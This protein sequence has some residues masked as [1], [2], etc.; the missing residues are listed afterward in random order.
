MVMRWFLHRTKIHSKLHSAVA[1]YCTFWMTISALMANEKW[2]SKKFLIVTECWYPIHFF[3]FI[4]ATMPTMVV[5][6]REC[7]SFRHGIFFFWFHVEHIK[8]SFSNCSGR[9]M[10]PSGGFRS[11]LIR[12][13]THSTLMKILFVFGEYDFLF[14]IN[15]HCLDALT[16]YSL[17]HARKCFISVPFMQ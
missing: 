6:E 5:W 11:E 9:K 1:Q 17:C 10:L 3:F 2:H 7:N 14:W 15:Q 8:F 12:I 13:N 4:L 16:W